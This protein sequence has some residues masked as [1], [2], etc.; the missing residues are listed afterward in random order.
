MT[1]RDI[2][3]HSA[4][5]LHGLVED[6]HARQSLSAEWRDAFVKVPREIFV[7]AWYE[8]GLDERGISVWQLRDGTDDRDRWLQAVY[9]DDTLVT[10][11]DLA[12]AERVDDRSWTGVASSSST[13][14]GLLA[15]MLAEL[16]VE[17]GHRVLEIGTGTGY[18]TALLSA[19]LGPEMVY[20]IDVDPGLVET[21]RTRLA[22]LGY[23][24]LLAVGDGRNG[25]PA[26]GPYDR[27]IA[28][29]S[30]TQI[31]EAWIRQ[32]RPGGMILTDLALGID[33]GLV[34]LIVNP[35]GSATGHFTA[36]SGRSMPA[37]ADATTYPVRERAV[38]RPESGTRRA[39]VSA[40][41]IQEQY[42]FRIALSLALPEAELV[43]H[44]DDTGPTYIQIQQPDG[45]WART[46]VDT[47]DPPTVTYGGDGTL[48][49]RVETEWARW[50]EQGRPDHT[51]YGITRAP[52]GT[53]RGWRTSDNCVW[54]VG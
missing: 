38:Y 29:C 46:P 23:A 14:P 36:A 8:H 16:R 11:L 20:S 50:N 4:D 37:R 3:H 40:A 22:E 33:G 17:S 44:L 19:R 51:T 5:R 15:E 24:P 49:E 12:T 52:D 47:T 53:M 34:R 6:I 45:S 21:A 32:T 30:V 9:S 39:A 42:A 43:Y 2:P 41:D 10:A 27:V 13:A 7:P 48:W 31:P 1:S 25:H 18:N 28:T 26:G 54:P 35:D